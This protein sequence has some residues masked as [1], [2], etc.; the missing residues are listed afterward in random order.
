VLDA[1]CGTGRLLPFL[2]ER[3]ARVVWADGA[4]AMLAAAREHYPA[5]SAVRADALW[6]PFADRA[7]DGVVMFRFLHH[8]P[9]DGQK[10][11]VAEACRVA[12]RFVV[13]SF[14]HPCSAHH[15]QRRLRGLWSATAPARFAVGRARLSRWAAANGFRPHAHAAELPFVKDLWVA[16]FVRG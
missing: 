11:A 9:P 6:L 15:L 14:F 8:L 7:V 2:R 5:V 4:A 3:G 1:P 12:K 13:L 16:S 10:R